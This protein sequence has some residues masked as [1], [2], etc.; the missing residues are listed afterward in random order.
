[1]LSYNTW[2]RGLAQSHDD[3]L[4]H[5]ICK[6]Y[7]SCYGR[8]LSK[9]VQAVVKSKLDKQWFIAAKTIKMTHPEMGQPKIETHRAT[10]CQ[11]L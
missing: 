4:V 7:E 8:E 6:Y 9:N 5:C 11:V 3:H 1:M 2:I 10:N